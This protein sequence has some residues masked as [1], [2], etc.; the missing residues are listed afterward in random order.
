MPLI[1]K[2]YIGAV[3]LLGVFVLGNGVLNSQ[4]SN[5]VQFVLYLLIAAAASS[6]KVQPPGITGTMSVNSLFILVSIVQLP[7]RETMAVGLIGNLVQCFW[8]PRF[9]VRPVRVVF[10]LA[11]TALTLLTI[12][13]FLPPG[14]GNS[15]GYSER[16]A[17][18][19]RSTP[20]WCRS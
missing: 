20:C 4:S 18:T 9:G 16:R 13:A 11:V 19:L 14:N 15:Y 12:S 2:I 3:V 5:L 6:L 17:R 7:Q 10:S 1:A 8:K